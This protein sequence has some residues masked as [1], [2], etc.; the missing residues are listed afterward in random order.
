[1]LTLLLAER[2]VSL[3]SQE[4]AKWRSMQESVDK[5]SSAAGGRDK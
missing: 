2:G 5:K 1:M 3:L 4:T